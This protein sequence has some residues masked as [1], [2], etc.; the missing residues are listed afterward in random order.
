MSATL[1]NHFYMK[2]VLYAPVHNT[3][4]MTSTH[5]E[6]FWALY[7]IWNRHTSQNQAWFQASAETHKMRAL[8]GFY[9]A[10]WKLHSN[11][12]GQPI[13]PIFKGQAMRHWYKTTTLRCIKSQKRVQISGKNQVFNPSQAHTLLPLMSQHPISCQSHG[14]QQSH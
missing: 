6:V 7:C 11:I 9:A 3:F 2:L 5:N 4:C 10:E 12:L 8:L 1:T 14:T 13:S